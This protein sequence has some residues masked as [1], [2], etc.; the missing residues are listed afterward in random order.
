MIY[1]QMS[2][3]SKCVFRHE[4]VVTCVLVVV[5]GGGRNDCLSD[6]MKPLCSAIAAHTHTHTHTH[7]ESVQY[8]LAATVLL[9]G[10]AVL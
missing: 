2:C 9:L 8:L 1:A 7:T 5:D 6:A 10:K 4:L 3:S